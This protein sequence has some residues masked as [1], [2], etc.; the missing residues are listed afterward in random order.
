VEIFFVYKLLILLLA[1]LCISARNP[2]HAVLFLVGI[3]ITIAS[4]L[5]NLDFEFLAFMLFMVYLGGIT[6]L[7]LFVVMM[8]QYHHEPFP[9]S[10]KNFI[11]YSFLTFGLFSI[12]PSFDLGFG[13]L[14]LH[15]SSILLNDA[16]DL[17]V[18]GQS[19]FLLT[20]LP[21]ILTGFI[22][23]IAIVGGV[24]LTLANAKGIRRQ[25]V[26]AQIYRLSNDSIVL[27]PK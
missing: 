23:L 21:F 12:E 13:N 5:Y 8:I 25:A 3:F 26:W 6:V 27:N 2:V 1:I 16:T 7:L 20:W 14:K 18:L 10:S 4:L 22:L 15:I 17:Q 24:S 11:I 9:I 19:L